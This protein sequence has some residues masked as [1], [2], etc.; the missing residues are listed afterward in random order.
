MVKRRNLPE[1]E[2][3][4]NEARA[5][6]REKYPFKPQFAAQ[7]ENWLGAIMQAQNLPEAER[8]LLP[9]LEQFFARTAEMS[10]NERREAVSHVIDFYKVQNN[11]REAAALQSRWERFSKERE[12]D[13]GVK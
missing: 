12:E 9:G 5:V 7:A 11:P 6:F 10:P 1:A 3:L 13:L 8:F 4:L 2:T